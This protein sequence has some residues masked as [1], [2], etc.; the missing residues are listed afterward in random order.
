MKKI[1]FCIIKL[2]LYVQVA[3][4]QIDSFVVARI[5][6]DNMVLQQGI[7]APVWGWTS[8]EKSVSVEILG[9]RYVGMSDKNGKWLIHISPQLAGG[10]YK[11]VIKS[12]SQK[13]EFTNVMF[14]EVWLASGQSNMNFKLSSVQN[15]AG[16]VSNAIYPN[17]RE[18]C[19]PNV[20]SRVPLKD[21]NG[22]T[23][24]VCTPENAKDFS[25][26]AY[27][28]ARALHLDKNVPVGIIHTSWSGTVCE[29]WISAGMLYSL[30]EFKEKIIKDIYNS[31]ED[32]NRLQQIGI[33]KDRQRAYIVKN[34]EIG[35]KQNVHKYR[36]D[37]SKWK[38]ENYPVY[39]SRVGLG[40]YK[41]LWLRKEIILPSNALDKDL[42]LHLGKVIRSDRT[43]FNGV[44][45]G[46]TEWDG[47]RTYKVPSKL[48]KKGKNIIAVRLLSEWGYGRL[49]D[50]ASFPRL[51]SD[52]KTVNIPLNGVWKYNG[53][54]EPELPV[55]KGYSNNVTCMYNTKIAPLMPYGLKGILW[56]Q[57]EGNS[58]NPD[59]YKRLQPTLI[60]DW[61]IGFKQGFL[62]FLFVQLPNIEGGSWQ[63]FRTAQAEAL[64]LPNVGMAVSIDVGDP[65]DIHPKN[66]KVVG[67]RLYFRAKELVYRDTIGV[68]QGPVCE[69]VRIK[70][71][72]MYVKFNDKSIGTGLVS[73][74]GCDLR[75][76]EI[77]GKDGHYLSAKASIEGHNVVVW[78]DSILYP[79]SVRHA[80]SSNPNINLYNR[81]GFPATSF[82]LN[83]D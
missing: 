18:F 82:Q 8:P 53:N 4:S 15:E 69:S 48:L 22:G 44:E 80:W 5:F 45:V 40:G 67:E 79:V 17:I 28:F 57:G 46:R 49:G 6:S 33:E 52:D 20:V 81:E 13:K 9:K 55:G 74:D 27:F 16:E 34:S 29:A 31:T 50:E 75:T 73:K 32:W 2:F 59:L 56:Y 68:F 83:N 51:Y 14:G 24:K 30:P 37:D 3:Y 41:L 25:A 11:L 21:L 10:P 65:Y 54:I 66:K 77:A 19:T 72:K 7:Y 42:L 62:P 63:L 61:R 58:G 36:Y 78:N 39:P 43:Y 1:F 26:V 71:N 70:G 60:N 38:C 35:L 47:T 64:A 76:F 12:G 23:W